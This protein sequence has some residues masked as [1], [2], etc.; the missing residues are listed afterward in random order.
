MPTKVQGYLA[1][2]GSFHEE[3][4]ECKRYEAVQEIVRL[5]DSHQ[6]NSDNF[7]QMLEQWNEPIRRMYNADRACK[8]KDRR[9]KGQGGLSVEVSEPLLQAEDDHPD[10]PVRNK[11]VPGFLEQSLRRDFRVPDMGDS[12]HAEAVPSA[13]E[14]ARPGSWRNN[15]PVLRS[16]ED[17]ATGS[18][19]E[20]PGPR[21]EHWDEDIHGGQVE[22]DMED[23]SEGTN[24]PRSDRH[25]S[26][27]G[28]TVKRVLRRPEGH[29]A[30]PVEHANRRDGVRQDNTRPPR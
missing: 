25:T 30:D 23:G 19:P 14:G 16:D 7:L 1:S 12:A 28:N 2:D 24:L 8:D 5:C 9:A 26:D 29:N 18:T 10:P 17:M 6:V 3:E 21:D 20:A 4:A 11:D 13:R 27:G 15:A 22:G